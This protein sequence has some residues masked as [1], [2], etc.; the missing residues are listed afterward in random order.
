MNITLYGVNEFD[1]AG[2]FNPFTIELDGLTRQQYI[3]KASQGLYRHSASGT[4]T[5]SKCKNCGHVTIGE[6]PDQCHECGANQFKTKATSEFWAVCD[7][8]GIPEQY[9]DNYDLKPNFW[10]Y[11]EMSYANSLDAPALDDI[12]F[13]IDD[14]I[15]ALDVENSYRVEYVTL[16]EEADLLDEFGATYA[17]DYQDLQQ[18][19]P[20]KNN[21]FGRAKPRNYEDIGGYN[22]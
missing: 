1:D 8:D 5:S 4:V 16:D 17:N 22:F 6:Q 19:W 3:Q 18:D 11:K 12:Y 20:V 15:T 2:Q 21:Y 10:E 13:K 14:S 7:S 9:I